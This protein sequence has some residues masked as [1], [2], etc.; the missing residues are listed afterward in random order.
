[1]APARSVETG[2]TPPKVGK[3]QRRTGKAGKGSTPEET[4][5]SP[6]GQEGPPALSEVG[7]R[8]PTGPVLQTRRAP[9]A[10]RQMG[11]KAL[12]ATGQVANDLHAMAGSAELGTSS[13]APLNWTPPSQAP[14]NWAPPPQAPLNWALYL[15]HR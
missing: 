9:P 15:K 4:T 5:I 1:M 14:L 6:A 2:G 10:T 7:R 8:T 12:P 11:R 3:G 13:Y